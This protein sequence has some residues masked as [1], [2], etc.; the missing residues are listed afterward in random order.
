LENFAKPLS[1]LGL[2]QEEEERRSHLIKTP[3]D[4]RP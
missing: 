3:E 4:K 1:A 2:A